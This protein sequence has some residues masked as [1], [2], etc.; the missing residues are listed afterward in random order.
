M[1]ENCYII[2]TSSLVELNKHNPM[3]V[4]QSV[5]ERIEQLIRN[6]RL[7]APKEVFLEISR[8]DDQLKEWSESRDRFFV[9]PTQ[10]QIELVK[11]ILQKYPSL[12][13]VDRPFDAD[14][15]VIALTIELT[16]S[17]QR[18]LMTIKRIAVTEEKLRGNQ[19][20]IPFVCNAYN[21]E[22]LDIIDMFREEGWKF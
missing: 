4:Y 14:P 10:R 16:T 6:G 2:D 19:I 13:E 5:W 12:I 11:D 20:K 21:I 1:T 7:L 8:I 9:E 3:D 22:F 18:T 17:P 15:W